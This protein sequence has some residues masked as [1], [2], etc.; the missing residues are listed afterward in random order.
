MTSSDCDTVLGVVD[1]LS[2][3]WTLR[4]FVAS[5]DGN[6]DSMRSPGRFWE[7]LRLTP[8]AWEDEETSAN[9]MVG[10]AGGGP[11]DGPSR[12]DGAVDGRRVID[13]L[14][15]GLRSFLPDEVGEENGG[16]KLDCDEVG[17][18]DTFARTFEVDGLFLAVARIA[19]PASRFTRSKACSSIS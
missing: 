10:R 11:S 5:V 15:W 18:V 19:R 17:V 13:R 2:S 7:D 4:R 9:R 6:L 16:D 12:G 14:D 8:F 3:V 1:G